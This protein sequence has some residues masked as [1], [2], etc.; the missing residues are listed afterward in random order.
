MT[1]K[2]STMARKFQLL[3]KFRNLEEEH[4]LRLR[5]TETVFANEVGRLAAVLHLPD[6]QPPNLQP[7]KLV[8]YHIKLWGEYPVL[9]EGR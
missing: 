5:A 4:G 3:N 9:L 2:P 6:D 7:A 8:G 1:E